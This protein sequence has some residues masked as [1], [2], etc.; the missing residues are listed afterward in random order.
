ML[1]EFLREEFMTERISV[2]RRWQSAERIKN[3]TLAM[4]S[5]GEGE[6]KASV[7]IG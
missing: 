3:D 6:L 7:E 1:V 5:S 2:S 4:L